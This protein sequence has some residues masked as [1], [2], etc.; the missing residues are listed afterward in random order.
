MYQSNNIEQQDKRPIVVATL[1]PAKGPLS[2][3]T[4]MS[5]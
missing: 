1:S 5:S 2:V 3:V 4:G